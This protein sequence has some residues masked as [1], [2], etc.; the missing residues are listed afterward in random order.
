MWVWDSSPAVLIH[1]GQP[2]LIPLQILVPLIFIPEQ[3]YP[4]QTM[5]S[6]MIPSSLP[7]RVNPRMPSQTRV[8]SSNLWSRLRIFILI[9][10][11][12]IQ[13]RSVWGRHLCLL[14]PWSGY[15]CLSTLVHLTFSNSTCH[16]NFIIST[17]L[18]RV[19][20]YRTTGL[21]RLCSSPRGISRLLLHRFKCHMYL[22]INDCRKFT[23]FWVS[24]RAKKTIKRNNNKTINTSDNGLP[25]TQRLI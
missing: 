22:K 8:L 1:H 21:E 24:I 11:I 15:K 3:H 18:P 5:A 10:M 16:P 17:S 14:Y 13:W 20:L 9:I 4:I 6:L 7:P 23:I 12:I 19:L 2:A 25:P